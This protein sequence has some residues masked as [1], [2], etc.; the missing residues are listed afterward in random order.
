MAI[1]SDERRPTLANLIKFTLLVNVVFFIILILF[2]I[3]RSGI[4][5]ALVHT[6]TFAT[7]LI[8]LNFASFLIYEQLF[9]PDDDPLRRIAEILGSLQVLFSIISLLL[10]IGTIALAIVPGLGG[11]LP[12][13]SSSQ[14]VASSPTPASGVTAVHTPVVAKTTDCY[15]TSTG[16]MPIAPDPTVPPLGKPIVQNDPVIG[17]FIFDKL[18]FDPKTNYYSRA[19]NYEYNYKSV[20]LDHSPDIRWTF[21][22][23]GVILFYDNNQGTLLRMGTWSKADLGMGRYEY[24]IKRGNY[25]Y[26][27]SFDGGSF[28]ITDPD[29]WNMTKVA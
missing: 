2:W 20:P 27:G 12:V 17:S 18:Q 23:D 4:D 21:R 6:G 26:R 16:C 19:G 3:L 25:N 15:Q 1:Y 24:R 28:R 5:A 29:F 9:R 14:P 8:G 7:I 22:E 11:V 13:A 10:L